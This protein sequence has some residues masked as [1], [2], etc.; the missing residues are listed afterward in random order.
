MTF[1]CRYQGL[2][3]QLYDNSHSLLFNLVSSTW[4]LSLSLL[5]L[6]INSFPQS[7]LVNSYTGTHAP[8][9]NKPLVNLL[10]HYNIDISYPLSG[11]LALFYYHLFGEAIVRSLDEVALCRQSRNGPKFDQTKKKSSVRQ[12]FTLCLLFHL[13]LSACCY[14][15]FA[16]FILS[17]KGGLALK[18]TFSLLYYY[19]LFNNIVLAMFIAHYLHYGT[20]C[21]LREIVRTNQTVLDEDAAVDNIKPLIIPFSQAVRQLRALSAANQAVRQLYSFPLVCTYLVANL[22]DV[23][24]C[25]IFVGLNLDLGNLLYIGTFF[26]YQFYLAYLNSRI[27]A[28]LGE[29]SRQ[30][31]RSAWERRGEA[32]SRSVICCS[33]ELRSVYGHFLQVRIFSLVTID[34]GFVFQMAFFALF[35]SLLI[36]QTNQL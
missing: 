7:Y 3:L 28:I 8:L 29:L 33:A 36:S 13:L 21:Q 25:L 35:Y 15:T 12:Q 19:L 2:Q 32:E 23:I 24:I 4:A 6:Y 17:V 20:L 30:Y 27:E 22:V 18:K 14:G 11:T 9:T 5:Y 31:S 16:E 34:Y 1:F 10:D 26:L